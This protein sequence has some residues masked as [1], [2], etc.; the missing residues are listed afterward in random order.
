MCLHVEID[1]VGQLDS[2]TNTVDRL[3]F[4]GGFIAGCET[5]F[6]RDQAVSTDPGQIN[7]YNYGLIWPEP[8]AFLLAALGLLGLLLRRRH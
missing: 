5:W 7:E 2:P 8:S 3:W 6:P 1:T 4:A